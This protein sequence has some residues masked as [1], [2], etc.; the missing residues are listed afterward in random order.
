VFQYNLNL[1][2]EPGTDQIPGDT[3]GRFIKYDPDNLEKLIM[4]VNQMDN[5]ISNLEKSLA[6]L[7]RKVKAYQRIILKY[8]S[9]FHEEISLYRLQ[10]S[11]LTALQEA[12][13]R[14]ELFSKELEQQLSNLITNYLEHQE[15]PNRITPIRRILSRYCHQ[16][17]LHRSSINSQMV[18]IES[19]I[20]DKQRL[21]ERFQSD[22]KNCKKKIPLSIGSSKSET[23]P[24]QQA[25]AV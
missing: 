8:E 19:A 12:F 15:S 23:R 16:N 25:V 17:Q 11:K 10:K 21:L 20:H 9:I 24:L 5:Y 22:V 18:E 7:D 1:S 6:E 13:Q 2:R 3:I 4:Q 14:Q